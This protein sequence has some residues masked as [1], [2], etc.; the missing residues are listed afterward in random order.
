MSNY[1]VKIFLSFLFVV[2]SWGVSYAQTAFDFK[3]TIGKYPVVVSLY[4]YMSEVEGDMYYVSQGKNKKLQL[5][6]ECISELDS[7]QL[8]WK[9]IET[10]NGKYNGTYYVVWNAS[11]GGSKNMVGTYVNA[12]G[13]EFQVN[14]KCVNTE[15]L[16][17]R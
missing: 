11:A 7:N 17:E 9:F 12:K 8:S 5:R 3:G 15:F 2:L 13:R 14:F 10:V 4:G 6:G 16:R 1:K